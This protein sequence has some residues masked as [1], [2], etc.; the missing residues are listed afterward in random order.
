MQKKSPA[1]SAAKSAAKPAAKVERSGMKLATKRPTA[2]MAMAKS[3]PAKT[4]PAKAV[5]TREEIA[6]RAFEIYMGRGQVS[7]REVE[8][9]AQAERELIAEAHRNN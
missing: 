7:G 8:D 9:W 5:P 4:P 2:K 3:A 6:R 1:K